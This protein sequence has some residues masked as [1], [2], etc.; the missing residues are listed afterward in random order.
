MTHPGGRSIRC[1]CWRPAGPPALASNHHRASCKDPW[2]TSMSSIVSWSTCFRWSGPKS[3][4]SSFPSSTLTFRTSST[5]TECRSCHRISCCSR[6]GRWSSPSQTGSPL[7]PR[8][9]RPKNYPELASIPEKR[10]DLA[11]IARD[12][13]VLWSAQACL[14]LF[15][16]SLLRAMRVKP[17]T[18]RLSTLCQ[19][20]A[21]ASHQVRRTGPAGLEIGHF[22]GVAASFAHVRPGFSNNRKQPTTSTSTSTSNAH[23]LVD[24]IGFSSAGEPSFDDQGGSKLA[25]PKGFQCEGPAVRRCEKIQRPAIDPE[26]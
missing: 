24:V 20:N 26:P 13:D 19:T 18:V 6:T 16:R 1:C 10:D 12:I 8:L 3:G 21:P 14:R 7:Q 5:N 11:Q 23:V 9:L 15:A 22:A 2:A 4:H 25:G 17:R